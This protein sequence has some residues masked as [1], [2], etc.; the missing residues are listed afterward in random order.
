M[1]VKNAWYVAGWSS[2]LENGALLSRKLLSTGVLLYRS[3]SGKVGA[4]EDRCCHR[5][6]PLSHGRVEGECV[7]CMYHGLKF[8]AAGKCVE[9]P[10]QERISHLM[11]VR[12]YPVHEQDKLVWIWMGEEAL[13]DP[14]RIVPMDWHDGKG[15]HV[16]RDEYIH[17]R[18]DY[19][20]IVDNLLDFTHLA[21][22]HAGTIGSAALAERRPKVTTGTDSLTIDHW[23]PGISVP[24]SFKR[25][26]TRLPAV[27]DRS[28]VYTW[29]VRGN[30]FVQES[31]VSPADTG[32][33]HSKAPET[34]RL[35]TTIALTPGTET[36]THYFWSNATQEFLTDVGD[37][38]GIMRE[39]LRV[40]FA[41]DR[42][43]IEAQQGILSA[44]P[45]A[46]MMAIAADTNL[47]AVRRMQDAIIR[48]EAAPAASAAAE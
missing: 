5:F 32:G 9:I 37:V 39:N 24:A 8:D 18:S 15:W 45:D 11:K 23:L 22:V 25:L 4:L 30:L 26:A 6:A 21:F 36:T 16:A 10:G 17:F 1:F 19:K 47:L 2:E 35:R 40:A 34:A 3:D 20:L 27:V 43:I 41:E 29:H 12:S 42:G 33:H 44:A 48:H 7:R 14:A 46:P 31:T 38:A 13:A 28:L